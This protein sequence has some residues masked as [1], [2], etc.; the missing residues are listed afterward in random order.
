MT[1]AALKRLIHV[2]CRDLGIRDDARH[3]LQLRVVGKGSLADMTVGELNRVVTELKSLGF[4]PAAGNKPRRAKAKRG[5][6]RFCHVMWRLLV[7]AGVAQKPGAGGLNAFVR[8]RFSEKWGATPIDIDAMTDHEQIAA[9]V[10]ALKQWCWRSG[11]DL[12]AGRG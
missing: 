5:D 9:V 10:E 2:G 8:S 6:V 11:I 3:D 4:R 1:D 7:E 12:T